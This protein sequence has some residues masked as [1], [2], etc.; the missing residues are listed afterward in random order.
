M[1]GY[2]YLWVGLSEFLAA[3]DVSTEQGKFLPQYS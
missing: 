1:L 2:L 3:V